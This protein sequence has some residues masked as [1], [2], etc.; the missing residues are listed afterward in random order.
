MLSSFFHRPSVLTRPL[1]RLLPLRSTTPSFLPQ[2][3]TRLRSNLAPRR[4]KWPRRHRGQLP[5]PT[6]GS[7]KGTTL[8]FGDYGLRVKGMGK[9]FTAKQ[10]QVAEAAMK[11]KA[12]AIK[13]AK[14]HMR[15]FPNLPVGVKGNETRMGKGKGGFEFWACW[16]PTGRVLF[17]LESPKGALIDKEIA[18]G[19]LK[20]AQPKLPTTTEIITKDSGPRLGNLELKPGDPPI[21]MPS[22]EFTCTRN[23]EGLM[24]QP[25]V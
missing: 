2:I 22:P 24:N 17:E 6:G 11:H 12:K 23:T 3:F 10:L 16:V 9:R 20:L 25:R 15:V 1:S 4:V 21:K 18:R 14:I 5:I 19:I 8:A 7:V 13:G